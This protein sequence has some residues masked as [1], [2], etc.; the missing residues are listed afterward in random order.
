M[1]LQQLS[2][3]KVLAFR[4]RW[5]SRVRFSFNKGRRLTQAKPKRKAGISDKI[6]EQKKGQAKETC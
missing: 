2:G 3:K 5:P 4:K 6:L 1:G